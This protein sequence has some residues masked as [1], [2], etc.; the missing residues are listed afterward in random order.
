VAADPEV[1]DAEIGFRHAIEAAGFQPIEEIQPSRHRI[2][3]PLDG[4]TA[5][6]VFAGIS[7][8]ARQRIRKAEETVE[9]VV[10]YDTRV[11]GDGPGDEFGSGDEG[12][13]VA[14]D[15]F[16]DLLLA[17]GERLHFTFGPRAPFVAWWREA[18]EAGHLVYL[19]V[20]DGEAIPGTPDPTAGTPERAAALAD[21]RHYIRRGANWHSLVHS[22]VPTRENRS[23]A[24][25]SRY[26]CPRRAPT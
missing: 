26:I 7:K 24:P 19:E 17:T 12:P 2:S 20:R 8:S 22:V 1:P 23:S 14:L 4:R 13:A 11:G 9:R 21:A 15:R 6:D 25:S 5:D 18:L 3:L 10:R 16:Y